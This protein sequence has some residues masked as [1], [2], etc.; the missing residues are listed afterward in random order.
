MEISVKYTTSIWFVQVWMVLDSD[1]IQIYEGCQYGFTPLNS[2]EDKF[3]WTFEEEILDYDYELHCTGLF[4]VKN[5]E[6]SKYLETFSNFSI[7]TPELPLLKEE[8]HQKI[9]LVELFTT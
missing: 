4:S 7:K 6:V 5:W 8:V 2:A 9:K 1:S 3:D